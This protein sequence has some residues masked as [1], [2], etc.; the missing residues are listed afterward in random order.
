MRD[1]T[2]YA[3]ITPLRR[4]VE[5]LGNTGTAFTLED[6]MRR[7]K[8]TKCGAKIF[9]SRLVRSAALAVRPSGTI[10]RGPKWREWVSWRPNTRPGGNAL[11]YLAGRAEREGNQ[12]TARR[13]QR[14][15]LL[16]DTDKDFLTVQDAA[17]A[18]RTTARTVTNMI[19]RSQLKAIRL[20]REYRI[21]VWAAIAAWTERHGQTT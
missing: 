7:G 11:R 5:G 1:M 21:P 3:I 2:K 14:Y 4:A 17:V 15:L 12:T 8:T 20:G 6:V 19:V 16:A 9:L 13:R 10:E 18:L